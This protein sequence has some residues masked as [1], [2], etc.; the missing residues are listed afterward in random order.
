MRVTVL[1][2]VGCHLCEV[3]ESDVARICGELG[4]EW[5]TEDVD[6]DD[7][8]RAEYGDMV[9][10]IQIDGRTHGYYAVE[11]ARLRKALT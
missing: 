5:T 2:R 10:V 1:T 8:L 6:A 11:E 7:E 4:V 9:P 3:A